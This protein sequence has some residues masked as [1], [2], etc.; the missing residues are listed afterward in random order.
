MSTLVELARKMRPLIVRAAQS[1]TQEEAAGAPQLYDEWRPDIAYPE[2]YK[3]RRNGRTCQVRQ[4]HTSQAGWEP[5]N[6][7]ALFVFIEEAH[8]GTLDDPIPYAGNMALTA[9]QYYEQ[10]GAV[11]L[12]MRDTGSPVTHALSELAGL[13]VEAV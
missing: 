5:E 3:L 1:L 10:N 9:G 6:A 11:Y 4:A 7:A 8:A 12:C 13:Y 2:N